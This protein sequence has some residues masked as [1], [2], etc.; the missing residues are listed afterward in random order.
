M[1]ANCLQRLLVKQ[2]SI[3]VAMSV[4]DET[5]ETDIIFQEGKMQ[6]RH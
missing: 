3:E 1:Y 6:I 4:V 5:E 2:F